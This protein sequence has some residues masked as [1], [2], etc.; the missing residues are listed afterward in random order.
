MFMFMMIILFFFFFSS[1][2]RHTTLT[3]DW[4]SDV[5]SSDLTPD[6]VGRPDVTIRSREE[7]LERPEVGGGLAA[8]GAPRVLAADRRGEAQLQEG[9]EVAV[10]GLE[11]L[12]EHAVDL[13]GAHRAERDAA[14]E[15]DVAH[16][17]ERVVHAVEAGVALEEEAI[18]G[19][20]LLVGPAA[21]E[22]LH[23]QRLLADDEPGG[24]GQPPRSRQRDEKLVRAAPGVV[25]LQL[26]E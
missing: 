9:V 8:L 15:V 26:G 20:L 16:A 11:D 7:V 12:P 13:L 4:S 25:D 19:L 3:C 17:V 10:G 22:R 5:C 24:R 23:E 6:P 21:H 18:Y 1:R 2:R 14:D